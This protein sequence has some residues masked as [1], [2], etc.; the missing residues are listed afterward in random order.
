MDNVYRTETRNFWRAAQMLT[1]EMRKET[2]D[3]DV[4]D[5]AMSE[6]EAVV[7]YTR[8]AALRL[9][10]QRMLALACASNVRAAQS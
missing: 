10:A 4:M 7:L 6:I 2:P 8:Q 9:A 1:Q 3:T 5:D